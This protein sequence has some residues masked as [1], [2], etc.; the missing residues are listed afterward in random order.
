MKPRLVLFGTSAFGVPSFTALT[1]DQRFDVVAVV[2]QPPRP[3][4][5]KQIITDTPVSVWAKGSGVAVVT[6]VSLK[7]PESR[8]L[9]LSIPADLYVVASYGLILPAD[10]LHIPPQG[11][12]NIHA[13]LLPKYRGASPISAAL[14]AGD[15]E[16]GITFMQM[17]P[18]LD[19]GPIL[20]QYA[21]PIPFDDTKQT[22]EVRLGKV[23]AQNI[24]D[25]A[26]GWLDGSI[27]PQ[28]QPINGVSLAPKLTRD[29]GHAVWD[30]ARKIERMIRAYSPWPGVWTRWGQREIRLLEAKA[31]T[32]IIPSK[33]GTVIAMPG[34]WGVSCANG[35][36]QPST[37]QVAGRKPQPASTIPGSYPGFIGSELD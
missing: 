30:D 24:G 8:K 32:E 14:L 18:G 23:A 28:P 33:P 3:V 13:S 21:L 7:N 20:K 16:T 34:G 9:V 19:T 26:Q 27:K 6:P 11:A 25:V 1:K 22:L 2:S 31:F 35:Y 17:D 15:I 4:G 29:N 12:I 10:I 37:V 36:I 5:R